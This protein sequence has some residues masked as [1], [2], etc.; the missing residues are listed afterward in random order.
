I[1]YKIYD[2]DPKKELERFYSL[3]EIID[4]IPISNSIQA[5]QRKNLISC[6]KAIKILYSLIDKFEDQEKIRKEIYFKNFLNRTS[7]KVINYCREKKQLYILEVDSIFKST[8][9]ELENYKEKLD[10]I[11]ENYIFSKFGNLESKSATGGKIIYLAPPGFIS[12]IVHNLSILSFSNESFKRQLEISKIIRSR[13][14]IFGNP[15]LDIEI[16]EEEKARIKKEADVLKRRN[17]LKYKRENFKN[18]YNF[19]IG[20]LSAF[21]AF[22]YFIA[23]YIFFKQ[24]VL[25]Y[26][27]LPISL[28]T[29][30]L[31][32]RVFSKRG[33][34]PPKEYSS[35]TDNLQELDEVSN[36]IINFLINEK[37]E[38]KERIY[39]PETL[40][41]KIYITI[42]KIK[43]FPIPVEML[44][45]ENTFSNL[46]HN[47]ILKGFA[48]IHIPKEFEL[49]NYT[50]VILV[51]KEDLKLPQ[52]REKISEYYH[53]KISNL[54]NNKESEKEFLYYNYIYNSVNKDYFKYTM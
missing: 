54:S 42:K 41:N 21:F 14:E 8:I 23:L 30:Y 35:D 46:F 22:I 12:Q 45:E 49:K 50:K 31:L 39:T 10:D 40:K 11:L 47:Y 27:L 9:L 5:Y 36:L 48:K 38:T 28:G 20:F 29:G 26:I 6:K 18:S 19:K 15:E 44:L 7:E 33:L 4:E 2:D 52:S 53:S 43:N 37:S 16:D 3:I 17:K 32:S 25:L 34:N 13:L 24:K 51:L 1:F